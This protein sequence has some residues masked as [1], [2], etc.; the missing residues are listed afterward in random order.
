MSENQGKEEEEEE[1]IMEGKEGERMV[2]S[3]WRKRRE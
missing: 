3:R 2:K 1:R